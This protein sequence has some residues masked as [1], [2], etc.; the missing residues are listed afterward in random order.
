MFYICRYCVFT[1]GGSR[2]MLYSINNKE[3]TFVFDVLLGW[4][5][6]CVNTDALQVHIMM[7][8]VWRT[9]DSGKSYQTHGIWYAPSSC[10]GL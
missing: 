6:D 9:G 3:L 2:A 1:W 5:R 4:G 8:I 10:L 7:G